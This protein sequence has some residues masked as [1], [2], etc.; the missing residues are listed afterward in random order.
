[1]LL[2]GRG[3]AAGE[4]DLK[5]GDSSSTLTP[6]LYPQ[7][8]PMMLL[9]AECVCAR[10]AHRAG[11]PRGWGW[12]LGHR[13]ARGRLPAR[14]YLTGTRD[15]EHSAATAATRTRISNLTNAGLALVPP[16]V[17]KQT[18]RRTVDIYS[19]ATRTRVSTNRHASQYIVI[20]SHYAHRAAQ[21]QILRHDVHPEYVIHGG[22]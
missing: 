1:M 17:Y 18:G 7:R 14:P 12:R 11:C 10:R 19:C 3:G 9:L 5:P 2:L 16:D 13:A 8:L 15:D 6:L 22:L 20:Y 4:L 21:N